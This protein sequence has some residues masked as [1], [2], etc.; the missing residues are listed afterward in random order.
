MK[1]LLLIISLFVFSTTLFSQDE[2]KD[3]YKKISLAYKE[4][5]LKNHQNAITIFESTFNNYYPFTDDLKALSKCYL[6]IGNKEKAYESMKRMILSGYRLESTL[7]LIN[8]NTAQGNFKATTGV[9]DSVLEAKLLLEYPTLRN[10][11][12]KKIDWQLDR[13][14]SILSYFEV[15]TILMRKK[16]NSEKIYSAIEDYGFGTEKDMLMNLLKSDLKLKR[17]ITDSWES[18]DFLTML[19]HCSQSLSNQ[20]ETDLFFNLLRKQVDEGNLN[21]VQY[22]SII[23]NIKYRNKLEKLCSHLR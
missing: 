13:Y 8:S 5:A 6:A 3:Y 14:L 10:E 9:G 4:I 19:I 23:D 17:E 2:Y 12:F 18:N 16:C 20:Q 22:A 21:N 15:H 7:P 11:Y 1:N